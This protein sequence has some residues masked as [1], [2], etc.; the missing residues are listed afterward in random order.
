[1]LF[2]DAHIDQIEPNVEIFGI[3]N[4]Q[5]FSERF[6]RTTRSHLSIGSAMSSTTWNDRMMVV[7]E[8]RYNDAS[9]RNGERGDGGRVTRVMVRMKVVVGKDKVRMGMMA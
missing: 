5:I 6:V 3:K 8:G 9:R 1:M 4:K 7:A 2:D